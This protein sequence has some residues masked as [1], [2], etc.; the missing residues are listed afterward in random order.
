MRGPGELFEAD[1]TTR[2]GNGGAVQA[3]LERF[4]TLDVVVAN[5]GF[6]HVS[7]VSEFPEERW[8]Q[9]IALLLTSHF[10]LPKYAGNALAEAGAGRFIAAASAHGLLASP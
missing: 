9:L 5:A 4:G 6:Q 3:A 7:P 8:D 2:D 1:V 10:L